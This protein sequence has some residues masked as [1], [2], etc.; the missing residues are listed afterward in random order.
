MGIVYRRRVPVSRSS[1]VN[2]STRGISASKR[3]GRF[4]VNTHRQARIRIAKGLSF[5]F[6]L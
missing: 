3:V 4:T 6:K 5:R 2:L 1:W